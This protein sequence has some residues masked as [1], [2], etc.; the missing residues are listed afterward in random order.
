MFKSISNSESSYPNDIELV[1]LFSTYA[2]KK[3]CILLSRRGWE[4]MFEM[5]ILVLYSQRYYGK[6]VFNGVSIQVK[7]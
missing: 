4:E 6:S 3:I 1:A 5:M 2:G 7:I